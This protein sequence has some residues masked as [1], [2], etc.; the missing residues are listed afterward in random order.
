L[1]RAIKRRLMA[2]KKEAPFG[3]EEEPI[4]EDAHH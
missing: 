1:N 2:N 3:R 4:G